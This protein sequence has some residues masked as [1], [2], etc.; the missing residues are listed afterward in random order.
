VDTCWP[1]TVEDRWPLH[2]YIFYC[3]VCREDIAGRRYVGDVNTTVSGHQCQQWSSNTPHV[4]DP[5]FTDNKFSDGSRAAAKNYCRNPD[6]SWL[7]GVWCYTMNSS[8]PWEPCDVPECGKSE[9]PFLLLRYFNPFC[10][11]K[12]CLNSNWTWYC[13]AKLETSDLKNIDIA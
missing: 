3:E 5:S 12:L 4:P 10:F 7:E 8:V 11:F 13:H 9:S 2:V 6:L 1:R